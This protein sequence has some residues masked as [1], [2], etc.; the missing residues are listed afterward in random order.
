MSDLNFTQCIAVGDCNEITNLYE[1]FGAEKAIDEWMPCTNWLVEEQGDIEFCASYRVSKLSDDGKQC[2]FCLQGRRGHPQ[3][4]IGFLMRKF[5]KVK[6]Y[7][8]SECENFEYTT[9]DSK[10]A[11]IKIRYVIDSDDGTFYMASKDEVLKKVG[12]LLHQNIT[13]DNQLYEALEKAYNEDGISINITEVKN[14]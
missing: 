6:I 14:V 2:D 4:E 12:E 5:P 3:L 1:L 7:F 11:Y 13:S 9:N 10:R 8:Y